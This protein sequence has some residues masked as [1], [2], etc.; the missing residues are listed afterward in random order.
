MDDFFDKQRYYI[1]HGILFFFYGFFNI[2][3]II[4]ESVIFVK[5]EKE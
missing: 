3:D 1:G 2:I 5:K 4:W